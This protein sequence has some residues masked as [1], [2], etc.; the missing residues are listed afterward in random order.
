MI[1]EEKEKDGSRI[2]EEQICG[3][4]FFSLPAG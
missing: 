3:S 2:R 1:K 4:Y